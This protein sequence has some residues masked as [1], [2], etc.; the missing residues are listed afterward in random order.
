MPDPF[1]EMQVTDLVNRLQQE[2]RAEKDLA[3]AKRA[4]RVIPPF[5]SF[6]FLFALSSTREPVC[7]LH[8]IH[9]TNV[10]AIQT[11]L[12]SNR[13]VNMKYFNSS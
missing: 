5:F 9:L 12:W 7:R 11:G 1:R 6:C 3:A 2:G 10:A 4:E 13:H 8:A